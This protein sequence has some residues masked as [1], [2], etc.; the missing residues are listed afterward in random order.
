MLTV[1]VLAVSVLTLSV[2]ASSATLATRTE[3][4]SVRYFD[5]HVRTTWSDTLIGGTRDTNKPCEIYGEGAK[6]GAIRGLQLVSPKASHGYLS[7]DGY[8]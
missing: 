2:S 8:G 6:L 3:P 1:S 7:P 5:H 4:T